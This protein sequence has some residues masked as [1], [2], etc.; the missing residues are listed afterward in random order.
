MVEKSGVLEGIS[1][2]HIKQVGQD[3]KLRKGCKEFV[4]KLMTTKE[5]PRLNNVQVISY[6]WC[7]D[8]IRSAFSPG[9][10]IYIMYECMCVCI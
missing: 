9:I 10:Y 6:C 5:Y 3:I 7:G 8:L 2:D 4:Q 1:L